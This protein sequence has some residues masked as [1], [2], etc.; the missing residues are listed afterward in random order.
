MENRFY[1]MGIPGLNALG[2]GLSKL[3]EGHSITHS[4]Q[5]LRTE[6]GQEY[7]AHKRGNGVEL[8]RVGPGQTADT[9]A[10][11]GKHIVYTKNGNSGRVTGNA[12]QLGDVLEWMN[13]QH[14]QYKLTNYFGKSNNCQDFS[15]KM[16]E[17]FLK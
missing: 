3:F 16:A 8:R 15:K 5:V 14:N 11:S 4:Y 10:D 1:F 12:T 7:V 9:I 6:S 13:R 17:N 2:S